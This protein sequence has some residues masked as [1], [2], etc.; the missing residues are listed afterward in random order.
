MSPPQIPP[1][2]PIRVWLN[3][4]EVVPAPGPW[5]KPAQI[6]HTAAPDTPLKHP[7]VS[8]PQPPSIAPTRVLFAGQ[9]LPVQPSQ[10]ATGEPRATGGEPH[11]S[12]H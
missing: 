2:T 4:E 12:A 1:S 8:V 7:P 11:A 5:E 10:G 3:G 9:V 6:T